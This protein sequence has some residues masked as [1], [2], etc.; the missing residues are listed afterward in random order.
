[1]V[2]LSPNM[3]ALNGG[4]KIYLTRFTHTGSY[5]SREG[6]L[7]RVPSLMVR[8]RIFYKDRINAQVMDHSSERS[9]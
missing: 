5:R 9:T 6:S 3:S 8:N 7:R 1:M 2:S 4:G